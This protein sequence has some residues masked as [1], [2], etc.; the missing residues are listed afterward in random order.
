MA[1]RDDQAPP[2]PTSGRD[3][4]KDAADL[5]LRVER[6]SRRMRQAEADRPTLLAHTRFVA[7]LGLLF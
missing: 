3:Q 1:S 6:Q 7:M 2:P 5:R 4:V